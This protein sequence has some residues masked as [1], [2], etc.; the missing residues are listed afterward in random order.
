MQAQASIRN[1][2]REALLV[3]AALVLLVAAMAGGYFIRLA[4]VSSATPTS[5]V[6][7]TTAQGGTSGASTGCVYVGDHRGC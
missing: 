6:T 2:P 4:T 5:T 1:A 7:S 3:F